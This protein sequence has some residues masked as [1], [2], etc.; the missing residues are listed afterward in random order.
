MIVA[1]LYGVA[2]LLGLGP[3]AAFVRIDKRATALTYGTSLIIAALLTAIGLVSLIDDV[4]SAVKLPLGLPWIGVHC[5]LD[6]LSSF[7]LV[8][9]NLGGAG[10]SL[11]AL[12]YGRHEETPHRVLPFYPAYLAGMNLVVLANDAFGFLVAW[13]FMSL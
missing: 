6:A 10:A 2:A 11:Y 8:V 12:G 5:R 3:I 9:V 7:F 13:E 4:P 1:A